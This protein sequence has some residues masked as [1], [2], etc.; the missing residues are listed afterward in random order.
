MLV[1][2]LPYGHVCCDRGEGGG[3]L[4][5]CCIVSCV[6]LHASNIC[7]ITHLACVFGVAFSLK[8][9]CR[10]FFQGCISKACLHASFFV[11]M[12]AVIKG[13]HLAAC[14]TAGCVVLHGTFI[15]IMLHLACGFGVVVSL[16]PEQQS[17]CACCTC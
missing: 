5:A 11:N 3:H 17:C 6:M 1:Y 14:C 9:F 7:A 13:G 2:F 16:Q 4:A 12:F 10:V 15:S 8:L